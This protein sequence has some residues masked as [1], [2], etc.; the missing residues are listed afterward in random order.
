MAVLSRVDEPTFNELSKRLHGRLKKE[1]GLQM[2]LGAFRETFISAVGHRSLHDARKAWKIA[3]DAGAAPHN[4]PVP[5]GS[6]EISTSPAQMIALYASSA[7]KGV[8]VISREEAIS[9]AKEDSGESLLKWCELNPGKF[10]QLRSDDDALSRLIIEQGDSGILAYRALAEKGYIVP[11]AEHAR[12]FL[13]PFN[14]EVWTHRSSQLT[15]NM[16]AWFIARMSQASLVSFLKDTDNNINEHYRVSAKRRKQEGLTQSEMSAQNEFM[17]AVFEKF[18][19]SAEIIRCMGPASLLCIDQA[20]AAIELVKYKS[21]ELSD[22]SAFYAHGMLGELINNLPPAHAWRCASIVLEEIAPEEVEAADVVADFMAQNMPRSLLSEYSWGP[23]RWTQCLRAYARIGHKKGI[24]ILMEGCDDY[25]L[26]LFDMKDKNDQVSDMIV[27]ILNLGIIKPWRDALVPDQMESAKQYDHRA[28]LLSSVAFQW[29]TQYFSGPHAND[30]ASSLYS[31][32]LIENIKWLQSK[33]A[34]LN[35]RLG[36]SKLDEDDVESVFS[37]WLSSAKYQ[38]EWVK[39]MQKMGLDL[40]QCAA[41]VNVLHEECLFVEPLIAGLVEGRI[42]DEDIEKW[43]ALG[44]PP[45][46]ASTHQSRLIGALFARDSWWF[47]DDDDAVD[48]EK[49]LAKLS[50][51]LH[52]NQ[53]T[54][55]DTLIAAWRYVLYPEQM[56]IWRSITNSLPETA[57]VCTWLYHCQHGNRWMYKQFT[58]PPSR[59]PRV[60]SIPVIPRADI[61]KSKSPFYST[62]RMDFKG[63]QHIRVL[64][65]TEK[66]IAWGADL[67]KPTKIDGDSLLEWACI[68]PLATDEQHERSLEIIRLLL[69]AGVAP[70]SRDTVEHLSQGAIKYIKNKIFQKRTVFVQ[71][72]G[73]PE[74]LARGESDLDP[75]IFD[76][77]ESWTNEHQDH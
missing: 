8:P 2:T 42:L 24:R 34:D 37:V 60:S 53:I 29:I 41:R 44:A 50:V 39:A 9:R 36:R 5:K 62:L 47:N 30:S 63:I 10:D 73:V 71:H 22:V 26:H 55:T 65:L 14:A 25:A 56:D 4:A 3:D 51:F 21:F 27:S 12:A 7:S 59:I 77:I 49:G 32:T 69:K 31:K 76:A 33:G 28:K 57:D 52:T 40:S 61:K 75:S 38:I 43:Y 1:H 46:T 19:N 15:T 54:Q 16:I 74:F 18:Q 67:T 66:A 68:M 48:V 72:E 70:L 20:K 58:S 13:M 64:A 23:L 11:K 35:W 6:V 17:A 45:I